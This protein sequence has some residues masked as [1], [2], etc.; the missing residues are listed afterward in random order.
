MKITLCTLLTIASLDCAAQT[1]AT[2]EAFVPAN[3]NV[4]QRVEGD[5]N[6]DGLADVAL[7]LED[8]DPAH[9][10]KRTGD[11]VVDLKNFNKRRLLVLFQ[12]RGKQ[13]EA[14]ADRADWIVS[15]GNSGISCFDNSW[16]N[17]DAPLS[18]KK[19]QLIVGL[20][21][22][23]NCSSK[24]SGRLDYIFRYDGKQFNLIGADGATF[25]EIRG[26][27][28]KTSV[29]FSTRQQ[30]KTVWADMTGKQA[31]RSLTH[32]LKLKP[33]T[34]YTLDNVPLIDVND[35]EWQWHDD[36]RQ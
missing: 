11:P 1:L 21:Y 18:I 36:K 16:S 26:E 34:L 12:T 13:F 24:S 9:Q 22:W 27:L 32:W 20:N 29:N 5:L 28:T 8:T 2:P 10:V 25:S 15:T 30:K 7:I 3:W 17:N 14:K 6:K 31:D 33:G 35:P 23:T 19:G 4:I